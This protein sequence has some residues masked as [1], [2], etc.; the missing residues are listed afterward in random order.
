MEFLLADERAA[1]RARSP[2]SCTPSPATPASA[3][4]TCWQTLSRREQV[5]EENIFLSL[6]TSLANFIIWAALLKRGDEVLIEFPAYEPMFK[7]PGLPGGAHPLLSSA[8]RSIFRW[9]VAAI[10]E[11]VTEKTRMI[12]LTDSHN[13]SGSQ[14]SDR[15]P[16]VPAR[17]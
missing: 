6:G 17:R 15:G 8:T 3:A 1:L 16:A 11:T 10:A 2:S 14:I 7:V 13:P 9:R 4:A 5:P 12:I